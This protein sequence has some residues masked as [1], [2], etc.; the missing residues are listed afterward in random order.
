[1]YYP[2]DFNKFD[3]CS[4]KVF[5][6]LSVTPPY[7]MTIYTVLLFEKNYLFLDVGCCY[8]SFYAYSSIVYR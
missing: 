4:F 8:T 1:M 5:I 6:V 2:S 7:N 3:F